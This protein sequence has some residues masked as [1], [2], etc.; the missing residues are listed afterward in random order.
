MDTTAHLPK[1]EKPESVPINST[2]ITVFTWPEWMRKR[3][4]VYEL[5]CF[6][7]GGN[8]EEQANV[9]SI[10]RDAF[11]AEST[12]SR[13]AICVR[14]RALFEAGMHTFYPWEKRNPLYTRDFNHAMATLDEIE[15]SV[16]NPVI[17]SAVKT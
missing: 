4:I 14:I 9:I 15:A 3:A 11:L 5:V 17:E 8:K 12:R 13:L 7:Q 16:Q 1:H 10:N 2:K 6:S